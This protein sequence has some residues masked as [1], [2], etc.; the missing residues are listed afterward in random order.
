MSGCGVQTN[1]S[2]DHLSANKTKRVQAFLSEHPTV[3][4]HFT[5]TCSWCLYHVHL[6]FANISREVLTAGVFSSLAALK[7]KL[8]PYI[9]Q[10]N[11]HPE[12]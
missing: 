12:S 10:Y 3:L 11:K 7:P 5:P 4:L 6:W 2:S 8:M 1:N 9:R